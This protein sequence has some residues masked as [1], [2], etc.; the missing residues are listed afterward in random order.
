MKNL[1]AYYPAMPDTEQLLRAIQEVREDVADLKGAILGPSSG[2]YPGL[3]GRTVK[4][5]NDSGNHDAQIKVVESRVTG[6]EGRMGVVESD[7]K[8]YGGMLLAGNKF[9]TVMYLLGVPILS[10]WLAHIWK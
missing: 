6:V 3:I 1:Q 10:A 4:L 2:Q 8:M 9:M 5:E 7:K